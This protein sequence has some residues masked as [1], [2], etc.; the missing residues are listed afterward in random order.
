MSGRDSSCCLTGIGLNLTLFLCLVSYSCVPHRGC[1][2]HTGYQQWVWSHTHPLLVFQG[3]STVWG[4][5]GFPSLWKPA[6]TSHTT[7]TSHSITLWGTTVPAAVSSA[8]ELVKRQLWE[9]FLTSLHPGRQCTFGVSSLDADTASNRN[10]STA[11]CLI[12]S[13]EGKD[14]DM[15]A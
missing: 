1:K 7:T 8:I 13:T 6:I 3:F 12:V 9:L 11:I 4:S 10:R 15:T 14:K 2:P 5:P